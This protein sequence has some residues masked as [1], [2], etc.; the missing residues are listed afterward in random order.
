MENGAAKEGIGKMKN[1]IRSDM[2]GCIRSRST[3][4]WLAILLILVP[5]I[6]EAV[7]IYLFGV[8][9]VSWDQWDFVPYIEKMLQHNL[10]FADLFSQ[11]NE[12]RLLIPR[13]VML[14][15]AYISDY[16]NIYEMYFSWI[17]AAC[18]MAAIF[19]MYR[20]RF[21]SANGSSAKML[22]AFAPIAFLIFNLGQYQNILWGFQIQVYLAVF[23]FVVG[24]FFLSNSKKIDE[25]F[26]LAAFS[27]ILATFSFA[28][29]LASWP[30]GLLF[31]LISRK[32]KRAAFAWSL[33]GLSA[34]VIYFFNW[35]KPEGNFGT[36]FIPANLIKSLLFF[37]CSIGS[38]LGLAVPDSVFLGT[39][40][41]IIFV[42][43]LLI[44][45]KY[46]LVKEN[47]M[48]LSLCA[49]SFI[50]SLA[51]TVFRAGI[52]IS[53][54]LAS[55]YITITTLGIIGIYLISLAIFQMNPDNRMNRLLKGIMLLILIVGLIIGNIHGLMAGISLSLSRTDEAHYLATYKMQSDE[56]LSKLYPYPEIVRDR[57]PIL[58]RHNLNVFSEDLK[59]IGR[60]SGMSD[61]KV[62]KIRKLD[63][64]KQKY[65][66]RVKYELMDINRQYS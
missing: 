11:H 29:G 22:A 30:A 34:V 16:N 45:R 58:E 20:S 56:N 62:S 10:S 53:Q 14:Q 1:S 60:I 17:L 9:V 6:L 36:F 38:P 46:K 2:A 44:L 59:N 5:T 13:I 37:A 25:Y 49:Y 47:A 40:L 33:I 39:I 57:A 54:A 61:L 31:I 19:L 43:D 15:L 23:G 35:T 63:E 26:V 41:I 65:I 4:E 32:G 12:H 48:W 42:M 7:Y 55:R 52:G 18:T 3:K 27:C 50:S 64:Y 66:A 51:M 24:I 21:G 28:N 8:N